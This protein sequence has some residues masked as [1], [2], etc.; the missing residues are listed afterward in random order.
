MSIKCSA[1]KITYPNELECG[2][3]TAIFR[4]NITCMWCYSRSNKIRSTY[5]TNKFC[6][7]SVS[8]VISISSVCAY[9]NSAIPVLQKHEQS[10]HFRFTQSRRRLYWSV[11][12]SGR[13]FRGHCWRYDTTHKTAI[14]MIVGWPNTIEFKSSVQH[15]S[16]L[17]LT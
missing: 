7:V 11:V 2:S 14:F 1:Y 17:A 8:P 5:S 3:I 16:I 6:S 13:S 9:V 10:K 12:K 15:C 4:T